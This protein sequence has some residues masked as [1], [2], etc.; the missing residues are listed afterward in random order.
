MDYKLLELVKSTSSKITELLTTKKIIAPNNIACFS[1]LN[2]DE[3]SQ[4]FGLKD[5]YFDNEA[6]LKLSKNLKIFV[7]KSFIFETTLL[8]FKRPWINFYGDTNPIY[9]LYEQKEVDLFTKFKEIINRFNASL[10]PK[11]SEEYIKILIELL[12]LIKFKNSLVVQHSDGQYEYLVDQLYN[13]DSN[14]NNSIEKKYQVLFNLGRSLENLLFGTNDMVIHYVHDENDK[15]FGAF[16]YFFD[17]S[18]TRLIKKIEGNILDI[19]SKFHSEYKKDLKNHK[20]SL[21]QDSRKAEILNYIKADIKLSVKVNDSSLGGKAKEQAD[22]FTDK[23]EQAIVY[24]FMVSENDGFRRKL[25][26]KLQELNNTNIGDWNLN[27]LMDELNLEEN[28]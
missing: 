1:K 22:L 3:S 15:R 12:E 21:E 5:L 7:G 14:I 6:N 13:L 25:K 16:V 11:I 8:A 28:E 23:F 17:R 10:T 4:Y 2:D 24:S 18:K 27:S 26:L 19:V 20:N 9:S